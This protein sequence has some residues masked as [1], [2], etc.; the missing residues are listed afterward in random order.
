[1]HPPYGTVCGACC[2]INSYIS[3]HLLGGS[4]T[5][6][7]H[8]RT[9][10]TGHELTGPSSSSYTPG[11]GWIHVT[12]PKATPFRRG[13]YPDS[14]RCPFLPVVRI[15]VPTAAAQSPPPSPSPCPSGRSAG[16]LDTVLKYATDPVTSGR[17]AEP[18][19]V[20]PDSGTAALKAPKRFTPAP[21][22]VVG[23][24]KRRS[25]MC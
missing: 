16:L 2:N 19:R 1:M 8:F 24:R 7:R 4:Q 25:R 17:V 18:D 20:G 3:S 15:L 12:L 10:A 9:E 11:T 22:A 13:S 5:A 14:C 6:P 21:P 23:T